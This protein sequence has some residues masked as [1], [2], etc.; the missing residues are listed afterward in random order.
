MKIFEITKEHLE[1]MKN[2]Y[3]RWEDCETGAPAIDCKRPYGNSYVELDVARILGWDVSDGLTQE[4]ADKA[5][6]LHRGTETALQI[7]MSIQ[8]FETGVFMS[9]DKPCYRI[10]EKAK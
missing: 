8:K 9:I 5:Y 10:W 3:V 4:Q 2:A 6:D 7:C 1:L